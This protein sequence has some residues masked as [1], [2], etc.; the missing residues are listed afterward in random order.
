MKSAYKV[1]KNSMALMARMICEITKTAIRNM[2]VAR[3]RRG[4]R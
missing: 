4:E 1:E 2:L 3:A